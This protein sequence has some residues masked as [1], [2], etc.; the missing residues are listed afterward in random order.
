[1]SQKACKGSRE[2]GMTYP[3][4][5][6]LFLSKS[7]KPAGS[8]RRQRGTFSAETCCSQRDRG[9]FVLEHKVFNKCNGRLNNLA[10]L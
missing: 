10:L 4:Q 7:K 8:L 3:A 1:M 9:S 2:T 6:H 5:K